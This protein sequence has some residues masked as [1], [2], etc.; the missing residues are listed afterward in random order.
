MTPEDQARRL[1]EWLESPSGQEAPPPID[2]DALETVYALRPEF[3]PAARVT[4]DDI[5]AEVRTGPFAVQPTGG[6]VIDFA[7]RR[8]RLITR[9]V[10]GSGALLAAAL[11]L[12]I[13][14]P[15]MSMDQ[16]AESPTQDVEIEASRMAAQTA[17]DAPVADAAV[18][19]PD[20]P[21]EEADEEEEIA[22]LLDKEIAIGGEIAPMLDVISEDLSRGTAGMGSAGSTSS[23]GGSL[24]FGGK[25]AEEQREV[26]APPVIA[27]PEPEPTVVE[28]FSLSADMA[29]TSAAPSAASGMR[30]EMEKLEE[31]AASRYD[32]ADDYDDVSDVVERKRSTKPSPRRAAKKQKERASSPAPA[33]GRE[34][35]SSLNDLA[36]AAQPTD[37]NPPAA[38]ASSSTRAQAAATYEAAI[39]PPTA[40]GQANAMRAATLWTQ[41]GDHAR[42]SGALREGLSLSTANTPARSYLLWMYGQSLQRQG[43]TAGA[44][45]AYQSAIQLNDARGGQPMMEAMDDGTGL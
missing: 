8:R 29:P 5:L 32:E 1:A 36:R 31:A 30:S 45:S 28:S 6:V 42:A 35:G 9:V 44:R 14:L 11:A 37:F 25:A 41:S 26:I 27:A 16:L 21:A 23:T 2:V 3:A 43:D 17:T 20:A 22:Q 39:A 18:D 4:V 10:G 12:V 40:E 13:L 33:A 15:R 7:S 38:S 19:T 34:A 24:A